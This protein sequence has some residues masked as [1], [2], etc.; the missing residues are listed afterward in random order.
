MREDLARFPVLHGLTARQRAEVAGVAHE[1]SFP[2]RRRIFDEGENARSCWLIRSGQVALDTD[3]P[4]RGPVIVQTLGPGDVLG[5]SWL[6]SPRR[7]HFGAV[8][9]QPVNAV[10]LDATRLR[11]LADADPALGYQL[12][13]GLF[14]AVLSRL[15]STRARLLDV[16]G[17]PRA[18]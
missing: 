17:S 13:L 15:Q 6:V 10:E 3:V 9:L 12:A 11:E 1:V 8:T 18:R 14:E 2:A 4:G 5:W 7:W 16:Y